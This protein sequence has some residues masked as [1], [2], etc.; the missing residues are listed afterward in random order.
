MQKSIRERINGAIRE[1]EM[2]LY[3]AMETYSICCGMMRAG[4][5]ATIYPEH[6]RSYAQVANEMEDLIHLIDPESA[7]YIL[8]DI[9]D[10]DI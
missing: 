4:F 6:K 10:F 3:Q 1:T 7:R 8:S 2:N 5:G 9:R